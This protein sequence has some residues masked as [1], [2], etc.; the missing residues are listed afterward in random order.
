[1]TTHTRKW[2]CSGAQRDCGDCPA[3]RPRT[4]GSPSKTKE[5][6]GAVDRWVKDVPVIRKPKPVAKSGKVVPIVHQ[7]RRG[8]KVQ[9]VGITGNVIRGAVGDVLGAM[10]LQDEKAGLI[11]VCLG[12]MPI[13][14][15]RTIPILP[16][17]SPRHKLVGNL[18][19]L[20]PVKS[21]PSDSDEFTRAA[22]E[23]ATD[24]LCN[25]KT[26]KRLTFDQLRKLAGRALRLAGKRGVK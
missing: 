10:I 24:I 20:P 3:R 25:D 8:D 13:Q 15:L 1:M 12:P 5:Y 21:M 9:L 17:D 16:E 18:K 22:V 19:P 23:L 6:C 2:I 4:E 7:I 26:A 11:A 14:K